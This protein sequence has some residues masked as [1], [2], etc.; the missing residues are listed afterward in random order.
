MSLGPQFAAD[1]KFPEEEGAFKKVGIIGLDTSHSV[2]FSKEFN[3]VILPNP[4]DPTAPKTPTF[5]PQA[6]ELQG[7]RVTAA[8]PKGSNDIEGSV[9]RVPGYTKDVLAQNV[10]IVNSIEELLKDVDYV[11][12]ESN[13]GRPHLE[14]ILPVLKA[15]KPVFVDKPIAGSLADAIAI[16]ELARHYQTPVFSSSSLRFTAG[17][18]LTRAGKFGGIMGAD[19]FSPCSLEPTH[20]DLYWYGIHGVEILF[21]AMGTGCQTVSRTSTEE[22]DLAVGTWTGGRVGTFRGIRG[23]KTAYGLSIFS[24]TTSRSVDLNNP[25]GK[26]VDPKVRPKSLYFPLL[27]EIARF[28][29]TGTPPVTEAETLEIYAFMSA[30]DESKKQ[31]GKPVAIADVMAKARAEAAEIVKAKLK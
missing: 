13:D 16:Y 18:Q 9:S 22:F 6:K 24:K 29:K 14:Q 28:F 19:A 12:L 26:P 30:A 4:K 20:P 31:G 1:L 17:A 3:S 8:Y 15:R 5:A 2:A 10:K 7:F 25:E 27:A 11:L 23:A 21:T